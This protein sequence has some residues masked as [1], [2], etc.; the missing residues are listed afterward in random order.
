MLLRSEPAM[1]GRVMALYTLVFLG[2]APIGGPI[3]G[4]VCQAWG[5]R[6]GLVLAGLTAIAAGA[7]QAAGARTRAV[8]KN[9]N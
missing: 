7:A 4:V 9:Q 1:R 3:T 5:A 2:S 8:R 6:S